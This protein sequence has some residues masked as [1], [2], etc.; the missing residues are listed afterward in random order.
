MDVLSINVAAI[1]QREKKNGNEEVAAVLDGLAMAI[2]RLRAERALLQEA[3]KPFAEMAM[4]WHGEPESLE[5][6]LKAFDRP[7]PGLAVANFR[8]AAHAYGQ[9]LKVENDNG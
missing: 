3:L 9:S 2:V 5:V 1:A 7:G 6:E 8:Q 4:E